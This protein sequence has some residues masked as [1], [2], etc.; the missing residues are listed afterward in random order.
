MYK[1]II[2]KACIDFITAL[3]DLFLLKSLL[4]LF[5]VGLFFCCQGKPFLFQRRPEKNGRF[6]KSSSSKP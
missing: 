2:N 6:L 1:F 5:T 4:S 3:V